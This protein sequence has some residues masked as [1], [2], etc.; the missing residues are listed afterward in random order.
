MG[1]KK[2]SPRR[3]VFSHATPILRVADFEAAAAYYV[4]ELGFELAWRDGPFGCVCRGDAT[5]MLSQASQGCPATWV[6][7]SIDDA[8]AYYEEIRDRGARIRQVPTNYPWGARE[9]HVFDLDGHVLRLGS[10][11]APGDALGTWLDEAGVRWKA[12]TDGSWERVD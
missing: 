3:V 11:A 4:D 1:K 2:V 12:Q 6:Y 5:V 10:D 7:V 8:D 9:L